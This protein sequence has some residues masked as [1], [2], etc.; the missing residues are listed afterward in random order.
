M[1]GCGVASRQGQP[2][3]P[4][5]SPGHLV[6]AW[7][8]PGAEPAPFHAPSPCYLWAGEQQ[9]HARC[10]L[11]P[12]REDGGPGWWV[13]HTQYGHLVPKTRQDSPHLLST[14]FLGHCLSVPI[15]CQPAA[16]SPVPEAPSHP[17]P[18]CSKWQV[19]GAHG[20]AGEGIRIWGCSFANSHSSCLSCSASFCYHPA[21]AILPA[22]PR[23]SP[24]PGISA[25]RCSHTPGCPSPP[26]RCR[27][28][29]CNSWS[30][31]SGRSFPYQQSPSGPRSH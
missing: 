7:P 15:Y 13:W 18:G 9:V 27:V 17:L 20:S 5:P 1:V 29:G 4:L 23:H 31:D 2:K 19:R 16:G 8:P 22:S 11:A 12:A 25:G 21:P 14:S 24:S 10:H 26:A 28:P 30:T 3:F 6:H